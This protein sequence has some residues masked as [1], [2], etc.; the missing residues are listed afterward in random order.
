MR[1]SSTTG[2]DP[3]TGI[4]DLRP[5][6]PVFTENG[7]A[8]ALVT[9]GDD[10]SLS[11]SDDRLVAAY[12]SPSGPLF[13]VRA[14]I[15]VPFPPPTPLLGGPT[16]YAD[17]KLWRRAGV[18]QYAGIGNAGDIQTWD[19]D[20]TAFFSPGTIA[21]SNPRTVIS[22]PASGFLHSP[23]PLT[24]P[25]GDGSAFLC[26]IGNAG[27]STAAYVSG[28]DDQ[29]PPKVF[30]DRGTWLANPGSNGG[31]TLWA[32]SGPTGYGGLLRVDIVA[33]NSQILAAGTAA[34][35][36]TC[37]WGG[38][39]DEGAIWAGGM[40]YGPLASGPTSLMS[41]NGAIGLAQPW[42][43]P[44]PLTAIQPEFG[45]ASFQ[46]TLPPLAAGGRFHSQPVLIDPNGVISLGNTGTYEFR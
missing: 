4:L 30:L 42:L 32:E 29:E 2:W 31:T 25:S 45:L 46:A 1:T 16:G 17:S 41:L 27:G 7:D 18:E 40:V 28:I 26:G 24:T 36:Q 34:Q 33:T 3:M 22:A 13:S 44:F 12:D 15:S 11:I 43:T 6:P 14:S 20:R 23:E 5:T 39:Y 19:L 38:C 37:C 9:T 35:L 8:A 10:F 21:L